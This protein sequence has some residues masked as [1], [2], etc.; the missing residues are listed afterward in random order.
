MEI[1]VARR[2][3]LASTAVVICSSVLFSQNPQ[4]QVSNP[5]RFPT[6][7]FSS[8]LWTAD[9]PYYSIAIDSSGV[10]TYLSAPNSLE[11]TGVPYTIEF[12][13]SDR[14]RRVTF[15]L[16]RNL[17]F[18]AGQS[19]E[20]A[21]LPMKTTVRTIA[22]LNDHLNNQF[23]YTAPPGPDFEEITSVFEQL[24]E[25]LEYGRRLAYL[26]GQDPKSIGAELQNLQ[27]LV[28]RRQIR[29][30]QALVGVLRGVASDQRL[31]AA[32]RNLAGTLLQL[33]ESWR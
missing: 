23:T 32:A 4:V 12:H 18:F 28:D 20:P 1:S 24:S 29:E 17:D 30:F 11:Q 3:L 21:A 13:A 10:A 8:V 15:N 33:A 9:P 14:T 26:Q 19:V 25:T 22:Y 5:P 31:D 6:I 7:V 2:S 27:R 16:A